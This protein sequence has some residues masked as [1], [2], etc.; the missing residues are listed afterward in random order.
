M[1]PLLFKGWKGEPV[2]KLQK[3]LVKLNLLHSTE[4]DGFFEGITEAA[5]KQFQTSMGLSVDGIVGNQTWDK[6]IKTQ[7]L[8]IPSQPSKVS[9]I[10]TLENIELG[11]SIIIGGNFTWAEATRGG[12]RRPP[13]QQTL[14]GIV[15]IATLA[16]RARDLIGRPFTVTSWYRDPKSNAN[17]GGVSNSRHLNGDAIDFYC[18]GLTGLQ[19]YELLDP[20]WLGGL[21]KY[22]RFPD[23]C[24]ID[25]RGYR[26]RWTN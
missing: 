14:E 20:W 10:W 25:A 23:L 8:G 1:N 4:V 17:A 19:I 9:T 7:S 21:G 13:D 16:Q 22:Q 26:A 24:H 18:N 6:L 12:T 5:V 2:V 3:E 15:R 11:A